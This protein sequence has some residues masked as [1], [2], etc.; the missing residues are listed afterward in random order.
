MKRWFLLA[1]CFA[2]ASCNDALLTWEPCYE[3][4][5]GQVLPLDEIDHFVLYVANSHNENIDMHATESNQVLAMDFEDLDP[6]V[7]H[8]FLTCVDSEGNE[9]QPSEHVTKWLF[10]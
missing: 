7:Y 10:F 8:F 3:R 5:D 2:C 4:E 6:G 9:S 1:M